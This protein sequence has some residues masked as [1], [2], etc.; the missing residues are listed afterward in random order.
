MLCREDRSGQKIFNHEE[1]S[2]EIEKNLNKI[3]ISRAGGW[4]TAV[5]CDKQQAMRYGC[6]STSAAAVAVHRVHQPD[7]SALRKAPGGRQV[8]KQ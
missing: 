2:N 8:G 4:L 3:M 1:E 5:K 7:W 6:T